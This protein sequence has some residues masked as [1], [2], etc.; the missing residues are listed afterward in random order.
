MT[1]KPNKLDSDFDLSEAITELEAIND[2]F[3]EEEL[4]LARGLEKVKKGFELVKKSQKYMKQKENEFID[5]K[6]EFEDLQNVDFEP[7][8]L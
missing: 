3:Q 2:W 1:N 7:L 4:D 8:D 6:K 5:I